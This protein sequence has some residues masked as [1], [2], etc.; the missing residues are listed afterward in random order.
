LLS[1]GRQFISEG[2][3]T[4]IADAVKFSHKLSKSTKYVVYLGKP[5]YFEPGTHSGDDLLAGFKLEHKGYFF[6]FEHL[7]DDG[8]VK[9]SSVTVGNY[10][11][12]TKKLVQYSRFEFDMAHGELLNGNLGVDYFPND[13]LRLNTELEY[14]DGY[15][16]YDG[17]YEDPIFSNFSKGRELRLTQSAYYRINGKWES[18]GSVTLTDVHNSGKDNGY[19]ARV[20]LIRDSW[21]TEGLRAYG[22]LLYQNSWIGILRG[23]ELGFTKFLC[24][25]LFLT[26]KADLARYDKLTYGKQ[27]A[28]SYYLKGTYQVS[29]F[30]NLEL[31]VDLRN[32]E[33]FEHD[34]RLILRY[35]YLFWGGK[36]K[37]EE[38]RK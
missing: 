7:R 4:F 6:G 30:S 28:T 18:F 24:R 14:Y 22:A 2:F 12:L 13:K 25:K 16:K 3:E 10:L 27:W 29:D 35:N 19:L 15:Y 36:E 11:Y 26:G 9:K 33:D 21:F 37:R 38:D 31:G 1:V 34:L 8:K 32:N 20:G 5:R 17:Y 23:V